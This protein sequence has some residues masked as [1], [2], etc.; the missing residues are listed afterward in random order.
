MVQ[1]FSGLNLCV[2]RLEYVRLPVQPDRACVVVYYRADDRAVDLVER[3][4]VRLIE[5]IALE[6]KTQTNTS[7]KGGEP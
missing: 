2:D 4:L 6:Q 1:V 7:R 3:K 5:V